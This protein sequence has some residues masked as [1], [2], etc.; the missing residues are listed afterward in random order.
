[1]GQCLKNN[2]AGQLIVV[3]INE[4]KYFHCKYHRDQWRNGHC[5]FIGIERDSGRCSL[6]EVPDR[7]AVTLTAEIV[8]YSLP[9]THIVSDGWAGYANIP[10]MHSLCGGASGEYGRLCTTPKLL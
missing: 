2:V 10:N 9:V 3:D 4:S 5:V 1:M 6:V 7:S 8:A